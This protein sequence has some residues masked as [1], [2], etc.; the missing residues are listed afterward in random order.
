MKSQANVTEIMLNCTEQKGQIDLS[1][2]YGSIILQS[3]TSV[4][5]SDHP[6]ELKS[7]L[8]GTKGKVWLLISFNVLS[9]IRDIIYISQTGFN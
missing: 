3:Q 1:A 2:E 7:N 6:P 5:I 4:V 8:R 9:L